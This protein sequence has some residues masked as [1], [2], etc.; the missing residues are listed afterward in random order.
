M[1]VE[2]LIGKENQGFK[3]IMVRTLKLGIAAACG[4]GCLRR[5]PRGLVHALTP[6]CLLSFVRTRSLLCQNNFN[7]ERWG[8]CVQA[9]RFARVCVEEAMKHSFKRKT[10][11]KKLIEHPGH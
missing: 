3:Y 9:I 4:T 6:V 5:S 7:H 2:N 1:P 8:I 11:G 10:F